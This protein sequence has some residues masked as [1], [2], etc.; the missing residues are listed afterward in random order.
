MEW[1]K[2]NC[3]AAVVVVIGN[4][5]VKSSMLYAT[6]FQFH[7]K[8]SLSIDVAIDNCTALG[9]NAMQS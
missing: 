7:F 1:N 9:R 5:I 2:K 6:A 4:F 3:T 8:Y